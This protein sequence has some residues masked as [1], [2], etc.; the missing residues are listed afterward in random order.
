MQPLR[1]RR[2]SARVFFILLYRGG[3]IK[4]KK[5]RKKKER[6]NRSA[7]YFYYCLLL[8]K[9]INVL[10]A[11]SIGQCGTFWFRCVFIGWHGPQWKRQREL[12]ATSAPVKAVL[13]FF[14][15]PALI[16]ALFEE[17]K[18]ENYLF[19]TYLV[20]RVS[21]FPS[22]LSHPY[23]GRG[24]SL[25]FSR[26]LCSTLWHTQQQTTTTQKKGRER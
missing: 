1:L 21:D 2:S 18:K 7:C 5:E 19:F 20:M 3:I 11:R 10:L 4:R 24:V 9:I 15:A 12:I 16:L 6:V 14:L 23:E 17:K 22:S 26:R 13:F 8:C 25:A